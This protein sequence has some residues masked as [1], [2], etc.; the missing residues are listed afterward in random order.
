[1][2]WQYPNDLIVEA[3]RFDGLNPCDPKRVSDE[4]YKKSI[5]KLNKNPMGYSAGYKNCIIHMID[6]VERGYISP[7]EAY[8]ALNAKYFPE[9]LK[10]RRSA[11]QH[12]L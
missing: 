6:A 5:G 1:M 7:M 9:V 11:Y 10:L 4:L 8:D 3:K 12:L 2:R